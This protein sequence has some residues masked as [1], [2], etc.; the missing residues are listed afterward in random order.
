MQND[1][2]MNSGNIVCKSGLHFD[3]NNESNV[4]FNQQMSISHDNTFG[5]TLNLEKQV[6]MTH[7]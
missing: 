5:I 3:E 1:P 2:N 6:L 7:F 4:R